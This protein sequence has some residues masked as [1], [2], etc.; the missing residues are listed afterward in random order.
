MA[1]LGTPSGTYSPTADCA[2][3]DEY[4]SA[5]FTGGSTTTPDGAVTMRHGSASA[6]SS[7]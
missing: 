6:A 1:S 3:E 7:N 4:Q 2:H 5:P